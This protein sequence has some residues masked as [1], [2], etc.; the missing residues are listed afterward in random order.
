MKLSGKVAV[1]TG[2]SKGIG[3]GGAKV[4]GKYGARVVLA[5]RGEEAGRAADGVRVNPVCLAGVMTPLM[6]EW[7]NTEFYPK[8]AL[9]TLEHFHPLG[10]LST[11]EEMGEV[12]AF[13]ASDEALFMT[14]QAVAS[15]GG[16][17][18]GY[19]VKWKNS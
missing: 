4:F 13:L 15:D 14:G 16:A 19:A 7:T 17:A 3:F 12:C 5:A 6:E 11:I 10:R 2:G 1:I 9:Q 18:L 8:V